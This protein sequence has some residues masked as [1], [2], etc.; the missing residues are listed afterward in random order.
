MSLRRRYLCLSK[1]LLG[2]TI[3][4]LTHYEVLTVC[5]GRMIFTLMYVDLTDLV[6]C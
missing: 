2:E 4:N 5:S 3:A 6:N 1:R